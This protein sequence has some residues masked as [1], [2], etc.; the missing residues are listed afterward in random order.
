MTT[1]E[2]LKLFGMEVPTLGLL[3]TKHWVRSEK[4]FTIDSEVQLVCKYLQAFEKEGIKG[5]D[6]LYRDGNFLA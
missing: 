6:R 1:G 2:S 5:I 4:P 3:G